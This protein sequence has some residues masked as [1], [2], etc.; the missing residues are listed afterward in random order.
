M[1]RRVCT[2]RARPAQR[3][4]RVRLV[5]A[6]VCGAVFCAGVL[7][8]PVVVTAGLVAVLSQLESISQWAER[9]ERWANGGDY[10]E[11]RDH[12]R[13]GRGEGR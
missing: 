12:D 1:P 8:S 4:R 2:V 13:D 5:R 3:R 9:W 10:L 7:T 6:V 11:R